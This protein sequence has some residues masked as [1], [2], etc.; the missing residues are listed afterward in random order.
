MCKH[1]CILHT[2]YHTFD[3]LDL[4]FSFID[5]PIGSKQMNKEDQVLFLPPP[6]KIKTWNLKIDDFQVRSLLFL[7]TEFQVPCLN[8]RGLPCHEG[9]VS[10][11]DLPAWASFKTISLSSFRFVTWGKPL[12]LLK[13]ILLRIS[14]NTGPQSTK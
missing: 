12:L 4:C 3:F 2:V 11:H 13:R 9:A 10:Y 6:K 7:G 1:T 14:K 5:I 8:F